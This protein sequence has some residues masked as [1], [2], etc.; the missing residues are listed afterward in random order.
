MCGKYFLGIFRDLEQSGLLDPLNE[1]DLYCIHYVCLPRLNQALIEFQGSWNNHALSSEGSKTPS[2]LFTGLEHVENLYSYTV[3]PLDGGLDID[4]SHLM[5]DRVSVPCIKF[6][7]C[8]ILQTEVSLVDPIQQSD[9]KT[10][11]KSVLEIVGQK[12]I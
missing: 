8:S 1:V 5:N 6:L 11:F 9:A 7:P 4:V 2:Q 12:T 10:L 3:G